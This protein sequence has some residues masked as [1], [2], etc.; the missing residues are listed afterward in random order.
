[1]R[2]KGVIAWE[3]FMELGKDVKDDVLSDRVSAIKPGHCATLVYTSGTTGPPKGVMLSHDNIIFVSKGMNRN[4]NIT[5]E[6]RIVSF[7]PLSHIA[8]LMSDVINPAISGTLV[9]FAQPDALKGTL[10]DTLLEIHP[11]IVIAV[12]R[13]WEKFKEAIDAQFDLVRGFKKYILKKS[14]RVG[15]R[16]Q[17]N[18][19]RGRASSVLG[20]RVANR[21]VFKNLR[22]KLG[23]DQC[24]LCVSGA[25]PLPKSV[26]DFY[27]G[28]DIALLQVYGMSETSAVVTINTPDNYKP[29]SVGRALNGVE[30]KI[31][32]P[33][34]E[35]GDGEICFR[36]RN[37]FMGYLDNEEKTKEALDDE[38][39][40]HSGDIGRV[41]GD[42]FYYIT[43]RKKELIITKGGE[44]IAPVPIEDCIKE[45]VPII[46]NVMLVG[47]DRKYLTMLV[48]LRVKFDEN[49]APTDELSLLVVNMLSQFNSQSTTVTEAKDD[50]IVKQLIQEGMERANERAISR[51][52][53][54]QKFTIL[55]AEFSIE[56]NELTSTMKLK[57][58][59]TAKKYKDEI[60]KMYPE[61]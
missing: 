42:G 35:T 36:G 8:G 11:T 18:R 26:I 1:M 6:D 12:P 28:F 53:R 54:V 51:A 17:E 33:D 43:G 47:D 61:T 21:L 7:L 34:P 45:E 24:R 2:E 4:F 52:A 13:V 39:W 32:D 3:E 23:L 56:G 44:N 55:P 60:D 49:L 58:S 25:A 16:R 27:A 19:V 46:S 37:I 15:R 30:L 48:T 50:D 41:D 57:R 59:V 5:P 29:I 9:C 20:Y 31:F 10:R 38:G 40:L 22:E 14:M